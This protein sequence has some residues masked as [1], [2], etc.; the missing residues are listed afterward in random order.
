MIITNDNYH[1]K[2]IITKLSFPS[3]LKQQSAKNQRQHIQVKL[4][5][6]KLAH[7]ILKPPSKMAYNWF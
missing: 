3:Q 4:T 2:M 5:I 6:I 1:Y 7:H